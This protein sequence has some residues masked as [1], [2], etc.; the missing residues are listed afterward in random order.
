MSDNNHKSKKK[1]KRGKKRNATD[2]LSTNNTNNN[3]NNPRPAKKQR[4]ND[5]IQ[6][7]LQMSESQ[8]NTLPQTLKQHAIQ[9]RKTRNNTNINNNNNNNNNNLQIP[10]GE[11]SD[12]DDENDSDNDNESPQKAQIQIPVVHKHRKNNKRYRYNNYNKIKNNKR[13]PAQHTQI[14]TNNRYNN[15]HNNQNN[16]QNINSMPHQ[17][18]TGNNTI[19]QQQTSLHYNQSNY[20][21]Q[22]NVPVSHIT[23]VNAEQVIDN[24][25]DNNNNNNNNNNNECNGSISGCLMIICMIL[26]LL[27]LMGFIKDNLWISYCGGV[28]D[29]NCV[30]CPK[31]AVYCDIG[32]AHCAYNHVVDIEKN[33]C[34]DINNISY[35]KNIFNVYKNV[36]NKFILLV[37]N[38]N[39]SINYN[40]WNE[41]VKQVSF[42][43][44]CKWFEMEI[45]L[46][47][48]VLIRLKNSVFR[49]I[50]I[51]AWKRMIMA[52]VND[53]EDGMIVIG[54][55]VLS[56][57]VAVMFINEIWNKIGKLFE[58]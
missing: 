3:T 45:M 7:L 58:K 15:Y 20:V 51:F 36:W 8:I 2:L 27:P 24:R 50:V 9:I 6:I 10:S 56:Y 4:I 57:F 54:L 5:T 13:Y 12:S 47:F 28:V 55:N 16:N 32:V 22:H 26:L 25:E 33:E 37:G 48:F 23:H 49:L 52:I 18:L 43:E 14:Q 41:W 46:L 34:V 53:D 38:I 1:K 21:P 39:V 30:K 40:P 42:D 44:F 11:I 31:Y 17:I 19:P 29:S 35:K